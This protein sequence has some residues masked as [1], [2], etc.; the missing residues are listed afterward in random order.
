MKKATETLLNWREVPPGAAIDDPGNAALYQTGDWRIKRPVFLEDKCIQCLFCW[1][2]CPDTSIMVEDSK[3]VA[4]DYDHCKGCGICS[5]VCPVKG[6]AI[7]MAD[8]DSP[9]AGPGGKAGRKE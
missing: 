8:E 3:V 2:Y 6:K 7:V 5:E 1:V 9:L 4:I